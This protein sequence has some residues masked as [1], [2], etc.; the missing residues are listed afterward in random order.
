MKG[1]TSDNII[2]PQTEGYFQVLSIP[3]G[4]CI[5]VQCYYSQEFTSTLSS[6]NDVLHSKKFGKEYCGQ[7]MLKFIKPEEEIPED[8]QEQIKNEKLDK[9][10]NNTITTMELLFSLALIRKS[11]I[12][13]MCIS[14][15]LFILDYVT[16]CC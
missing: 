4:K 1:V 7:L 5:D 14:L 13:M 10:Q 2:I 11:P 8:Q 15:E 16:L 9:S 12:K 3:E 6:K